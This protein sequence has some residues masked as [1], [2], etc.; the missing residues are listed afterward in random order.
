M[1][2][3]IFV[4]TGKRHPINNIILLQKVQMQK[5]AQTSQAHHM[6]AKLLPLLFTRES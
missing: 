4:L 2:P 1:P 3:P 5:D 6:S